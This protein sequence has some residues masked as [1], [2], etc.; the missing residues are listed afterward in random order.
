MRTRTRI[1][2]FVVFHLHSH[3]LYWVHFESCLFAIEYTLLGRRTTT[4]T[5]I[6]TKSNQVSRNWCFRQPNAHT[7]I[8]LI[9][10]QSWAL[11]AKKWEKSRA[12]I[13][14]PP[15]STFGFIVCSEIKLS[16]PMRFTFKCSYTNRCWCSSSSSNSAA[17]TIIINIRRNNGF[18][19]FTLQRKRSFVCRFF[20]VL[21]LFFSFF[22]QNF[23]RTK[24]IINFMC[25]SWLS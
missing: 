9:T 6:K 5:T 11:L 18:Y 12:D 3:L 13:F 15:P 22:F 19:C 10:F 20:Y 2:N 14:S 4:T 24:K 7:R 8:T 23:N 25:F 1:H 16:I 17:I 21:F